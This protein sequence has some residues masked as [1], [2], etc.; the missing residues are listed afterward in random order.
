M[1]RPGPAGSIRQ[2][3]II[4]RG[5]PAEQTGVF[6][7]PGTPTNLPLD[8]AQQWTHVTAPALKTR[9]HLLFST[10][11]PGSSSGLVSYNLLKKIVIH[12]A[13]LPPFTNLW[14]GRINSLG[15]GVCI[16]PR[17]ASRHRGRS[18]QGDFYE[19]RS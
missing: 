8:G 18:V 3:S 12:V 6:L 1:R 4:E 15:F 9:G 7:P 2:A 14:G 10:S 13:K 17:I 16:A 19:N 5:M 11:L